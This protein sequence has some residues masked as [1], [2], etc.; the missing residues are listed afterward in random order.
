MSVC[1]NTIVTTTEQTYEYFE[2]QKN[3]ALMLK[4]RGYTVEQKPWHQDFEAFEVLWTTNAGFIAFT[5]V[6]EKEDDVVVTFFPFDEKLRIN[7]IRDI[8]DV[9]KEKKYYHFIIVYS[10]LITS[11]AKQQL[12]VLRCN[13]E[14]TLRIE[15]FN[16]RAFQYD[17][18][19]HKNVPAQRL[20]TKAETCELLGKFKIE[21]GQL[22]KIYNTDPI[23]QY[24]GTRVHDVVEIVRPSPEGYFYK[25]WRVCIKGNILK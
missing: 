19:A 1:C 6:A 23:A 13:S 22:P 25:A 10:G 24:L 16:I 12:A 11:F 14:M 8:I 21:K 2:A 17:P 9:C 3:V 15:T 5:L 20:L 18:L 4:R 7:S